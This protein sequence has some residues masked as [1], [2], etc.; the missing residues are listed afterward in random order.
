MF[1]GKK[2]SE[3]NPNQPQTLQYA[4]PIF[5]EP[6]V[7]R[8]AIASI[9]T[10][11]ICCPCVAALLAELL[12]KLM[13]KFIRESSLRYSLSFYLMLVIMVAC[14]G[15]PIVALIRIRRSNGGRMG[16]SLAVASLLF[17]LFWWIVLIAIKLMIRNSSFI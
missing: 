10:G 8:L 3:V 6:R 11:L 12:T 4:K 1:S 5:R 2:M 17:A 7:S 13:P 14:L 16:K 15:T 9:P